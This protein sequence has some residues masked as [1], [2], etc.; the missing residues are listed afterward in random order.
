MSDLSNVS[1]RGRESSEETASDLVAPEAAGLDAMDGQ[2]GHLDIGEYAPLSKPRGFKMYVKP[3]LYNPA[4][5]RRL[6]G[7][8]EALPASDGWAYDPHST[9][10][11]WSTSYLPPAEREEGEAADFAARLKSHSAE[12]VVGGDLPVVIHDSLLQLR[13]QLMGEEA[14]GS[15][16]AMEGDGAV[17][18]A[19]GELVEF[20]PLASTRVTCLA[21]GPEE[22][23]NGDV[24]YNQVP[25][26]IPRPPPLP[27]CPGTNSQLNSGVFLQ[28]TYDELKK[29][30]SLAGNTVMASI[31]ATASL[32]LQEE[33]RRRD[34]GRYG[35]YYQ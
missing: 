18:Q 12:K 10:G 14:Q 5:R 7:D 32:A 20:R 21:Q 35:T 23:G 2:V 33:K 9:F 22:R 17:K 30:A 6:I 4:K 27:A 19:E 8:D 16:L 3:G 11:R 15:V 29:V 24:R 13:L 25:A 34:E 26:E 31:A 1:G 28:S